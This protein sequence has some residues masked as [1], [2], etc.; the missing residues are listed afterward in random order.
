MKLLLTIFVFCC[1][2]AN[3]QT[4]WQPGRYNAKDSV[5]FN[6]VIWEAVRVF[7][8]GKPPTNTNSWWVN[9]G[10]FVAKKEPELI[11]TSKEIIVDTVNRIIKY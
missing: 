7:N 6:G 4:A 8:S 2:T 10:D 5:V 3:G 11:L 1:F 9:R